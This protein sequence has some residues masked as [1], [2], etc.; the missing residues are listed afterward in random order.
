MLDYFKF[1]HLE[2]LLFHFFLF[3]LLHHRLRQRF[4]L[5]HFQLRSAI[6]IMRLAFTCSSLIGK[7]A[8]I[9]F[10]SSLLRIPIRPLYI[11]KRLQSLIRRRQLFLRQ[12]LLLSERCRNLLLR[13]TLRLLL[14]LQFLHQ[15]PSWIRRSINSSNICLGYAFYQHLLTCCSQRTFAFHWR[16]IHLLYLILGLLKKVLLLISWRYLDLW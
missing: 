13:S 10:F 11:L 9:A 3:H 6:S 5:Q 12:L 15:A 14:D 1:V 2:F 16:L 7:R 4:I 8:L